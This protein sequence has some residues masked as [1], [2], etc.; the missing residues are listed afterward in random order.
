MRDAL[1]KEIV[2]GGGDGAGGGGGATAAIA[3]EEDDDSNDGASAPPSAKK[4]NLGDLLQKRRAHVPLRVRADTA[5]T[6]YLQE[7]PDPT[8]N[9]LTWW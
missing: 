2:E 8:D 9:L 7:Q 6:I 4:R 5:P 3:T 1:F